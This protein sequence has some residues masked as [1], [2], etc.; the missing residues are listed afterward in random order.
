MTGEFHGRRLRLLV[1]DDDPFLSTTLV[2]ALQRALPSHTVIRMAHSLSEASSLVGTEAFNAVLV[3][4]NLPDG[5]GGEFL[6]TLCLLGGH[7]IA[8]FLTSAKDPNLTDVPALLREFPQIT[9][10]E[11]PFLFDAVARQVLQAVEPDSKCGPGHYGL[12]LFDLIQAYS[13]ARKSA[14]LRILLPDGGMGM[15]AIREGDL[16]HA[17]L[18]SAVGQEALLRI[19]RHRKGRIRIDETCST[20]LRTFTIPTGHVLIDTSRLLDEVERQESSSASDVATAAMSSF[21]A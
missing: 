8:L 1:A 13:L 16:V 14:T 4:H 20:A 11:K 5:N 15:V 21:Q 2:L 3:E 10:I 9:F 6:R 17:A 18:G 7:R 19:A 12:E